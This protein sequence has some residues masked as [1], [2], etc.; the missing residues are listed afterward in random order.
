MTTAAAIVL[1]IGVGVWITPLIGIA[2]VL[3]ADR[4]QTWNLHHAGLTEWARAR[5][6]WGD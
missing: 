6:T 3:A 2:M 5:N 1:G 4:L